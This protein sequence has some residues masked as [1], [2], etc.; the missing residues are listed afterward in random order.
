MFIKAK[1]IQLSRNDELIVFNHIYRPGEFM[2]ITDM[3][4]HERL[5]LAGKILDLASQWSNAWITVSM[6]ANSFSVDQI[7]RA[8]KL[9]V[10]GLQVDPLDY[11]DEGALEA[12]SNAAFEE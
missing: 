11:L 12:M 4:E 6:T 2:I 8:Y 5:E 7:N 10:A 3:P 9:T 1:I